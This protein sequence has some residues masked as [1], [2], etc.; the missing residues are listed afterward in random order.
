M[1][2]AKLRRSRGFFTSEVLAFLLVALL[3]AF[4]LGLLHMLF[5]SLVLLC[6]YTLIHLL[7]KQR[8]EETKLLAKTKAL[9]GARLCFIRKLIT[10]AYEADKDSFHRKF[11]AS[12]RVEEL[13]AAGVVE[14][15]HEMLN[16][17]IHYHMTE[18]D[19]RKALTEKD[20]ELCCLLLHGFSYPQLTVVY[21]LK[22]VNYAYTKRHRLKTKLD[23]LGLGD[24]L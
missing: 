1:K 5:F 19:N 3:I 7:N 10:L 24:A 8:Q 11:L 12:V 13:R 22:S 9:A 20:I 18:E 2:K 16:E 14:V 6:A 15:H 4:F 21:N 23:L 17:K